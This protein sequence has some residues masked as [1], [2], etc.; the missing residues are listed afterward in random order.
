MYF[1]IKLGSINCDT[2]FFKAYFLL[3]EMKWL[4]KNE[5]QLSLFEKE[6]HW[7]LIFWFQWPV[8]NFVLNYFEFVISQHL[9]LE[10]FIL[11]KSL[12]F[13]S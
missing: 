12:F 1:T 6:A 10:K 11:R 4:W 8:Y 9:E 2:W 13:E 7:K 3:F 5:F